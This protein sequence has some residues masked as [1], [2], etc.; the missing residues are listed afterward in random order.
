MIFTGGAIALATV[1]PADNTRILIY[2]ALAGAGFGAPLVLIIAGI[3]LA[4]PH[5][6]IATATGLTVAARS[7]GGTVFVSVYA[8]LIT[9]RTGEKIPAYVASAALKAGLPPKSLMAF[10]GALATNDAA[11]LPLIPGV[12]PAIIGAGVVAL[13]QAFADSIRVVYIIA[14]VFPRWLV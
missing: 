12:T 5:H 6:L 4:S 7:L 11:A 13:K 3:Q 10:V 14:A 2:S 1:Q 9:S 8:A